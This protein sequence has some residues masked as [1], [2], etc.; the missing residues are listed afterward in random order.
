VSDNG[1]AFERIVRENFARACETLELDPELRE[2][3]SVPR[4]EVS[5]ALPVQMDDGSVRV[6]RGYRVSHSSARGPSKG[7]LRFASGVTLKE[8]RSLATLMSWKCAVMDL[9]FGGGK[10][11]VAVSTR[12]VSDR[13]LEAITRAY[14]REIAPFIGPDR[15]IP[16]PDMYTDERVMG[17]IMDAY[18]QLRGEEVPG[19]VTGKPLSLGGSEGRETAT[20]RGLV[21]TLD[22]AARERGIGLE[23]CTVAVQ[24]FG[25]AGRKIS[26]ILGDEFG[27]RVVAVSDSQ[28][29]IYEPEGLDLDAVEEQKDRTGTVVDE[30]LGRVVSN[31]SI[32]TLDVDVLIPAAVEGVLT[33]EIAPEVNAHIV[34]EAANGPTLP[35]ADRILQE[36]GVMVLPDILASGGGVTVSY[37]EWVQNK[38]GDRWPLKRVWSELRTRM[39]ESFREVYELA[40][41]HDG[42]MRLAAYMIG[43]GRVAE[44]VRARGG[45]GLE[46]VAGPVAGSAPR[47]PATA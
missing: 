14:T 47:H 40:R 24:G 3:L 28:G 20:A 46:P 6:Y 27:A 29:A 42:D 36:K 38:L 10:G 26:R 4:R 18:S 2:I 35:D 1:S 5:V 44:A 13:E 33:A 37:F 30:S 31:G 41:E 21:L 25:N 15:D 17:W 45:F 7:G 12:T 43:V 16:A 23:G 19:V 8:V 22:A 32:L 39:D 34:A 11:G 9:P